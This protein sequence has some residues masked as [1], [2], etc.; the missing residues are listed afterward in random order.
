MDTF[1]K[2]PCLVGLIWTRGINTTHHIRYSLELDTTKYC[3]HPKRLSEQGSRSHRAEK[4]IKAVLATRVAKA[5]EPPK[6]LSYL[7]NQ[8][9]RRDRGVKVIIAA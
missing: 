3:L 2:S 4:V 6:G 7:F 8:G 1:I 5:T 9:S